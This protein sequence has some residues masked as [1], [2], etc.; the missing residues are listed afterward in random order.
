[1]KKLVFCWCLKLQTQKYQCVTI[2]KSRG[3]N[4][5]PR[6]CS[7]A[8]FASLVPFSV[9]ISCCRGATPKNRGARNILTRCSQN[10]L[11]LLEAT[12]P[13]CAIA[14]VCLTHLL[15]SR[16]AFGSEVAFSLSFANNH[17]TPRKP[18]ITA[19][20]CQSLPLRMDT[21]GW[22]CPRSSA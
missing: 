21:E 19:D 6:G 1:M 15:S 9:S 2:S 5:F 4:M 16:V 13:D 3:F 22:H 12:P 18:P 7:V 8:S 17:S 10:I 14:R 20:P 11:E